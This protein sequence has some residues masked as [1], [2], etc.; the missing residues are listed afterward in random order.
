MLFSRK[1]PPSEFYVYM[2]L[3]EDGTPY[4]VGKGSGI[5]AWKNY[6]EHR[7]PK[8]KNQIVITHW[9]LTEVWALALERWF[10]RWY[11][12]KDIET[13]ILRNFTNGGDGVVGLRHK[14]ETKKYMATL[15]TGVNN[16]R[17]D[18]RIHHFLNKK[19]GR[20]FIGTQRN[21]QLSYPEINGGHLSSMIS[22]S[23]KIKSIKGWQLLAETE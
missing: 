18:H 6:P 19:D 17:Y 3:R 7:T 15:K 23:P 21:F 10:I 14:S 5:R 22:G 1:N 20:S 9:G 16:V 8:N 2:Y 4:Y 13:G 12:R 11:G